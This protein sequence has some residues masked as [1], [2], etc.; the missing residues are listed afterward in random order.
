MTRRVSDA[1]RDADVLDLTQLC[2]KEG[3]YVW[4]VCV[5]VYCLDH[6]GQGG[7]KGGGTG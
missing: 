5:D 7:G 3:E 1:L 6:D 2:I 4:R